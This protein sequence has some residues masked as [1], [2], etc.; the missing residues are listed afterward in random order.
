MNHTQLQSEK[1]RKVTVEESKIQQPEKVQL[2]GI[3]KKQFMNEIQ[4]QSEKVH[5]VTV[6]ESST[7]TARKGTTV[8]R[9]KVAVY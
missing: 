5:K 8:G 6:E 9:T 3:P 7:I 2:K 1:V 4:L